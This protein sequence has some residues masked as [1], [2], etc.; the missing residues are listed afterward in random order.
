MVEGVDPRFLAGVAYGSRVD[1]S[2]AVRGDG[3]PDGGAVAA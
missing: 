3:D 1:V 2:G